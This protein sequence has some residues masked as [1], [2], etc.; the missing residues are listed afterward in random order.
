MRFKL[1]A[2]RPFLSTNNEVFCTNSRYF[3]YNFNITIVKQ[4]FYD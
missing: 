1:W 2:N 4:L 3:A